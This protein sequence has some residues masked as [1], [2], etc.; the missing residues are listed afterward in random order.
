MLAFAEEAVKQVCKPKHVFAFSIGAVK[1]VLASLEMCLHL[2]KELL[3][4]CWRAWKSVGIPKRSCEKNVGKLRKVLAL[5]KELVK[6]GL[7][8]LEMCW[9]SLK[10]C[11]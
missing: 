1:K 3:K 2:L 10:S 9:H 8:S 7:A 6:N 11:L 5:L 4:M